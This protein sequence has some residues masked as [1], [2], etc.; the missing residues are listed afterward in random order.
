MQVITAGDPRFLVPPDP[1]GVDVI[2]MD[3]LA[4]HRRR[5]LAT[6]V[7]DTRTR[8]VLSSSSKVRGG[9]PAFLHE[10]FIRLGVS[11]LAH[12]HGMTAHGMAIGEDAPQARHSRPTHAIVR[13]S[14]AKE[15]WTVRARVAL[16]WDLE[17]ERKTP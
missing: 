14:A 5:R 15:I 8:R 3:D 11:D 2:G 4:L 6:V 1:A 7:V 10:F 17:I 9:F 12:E 13:R 16:S